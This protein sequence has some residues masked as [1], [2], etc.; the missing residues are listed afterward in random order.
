MKRRN[1]PN[2]YDFTPEQLEAIMH[3]VE[4]HWGWNM[5]SGYDIAENKMFL[6]AQEG[7]NLPVYGWTIDRD[8]E[9]TERV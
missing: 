4:D 9:V 6:Y 3:L 5:Q 7:P 8:G 2:K 1:D